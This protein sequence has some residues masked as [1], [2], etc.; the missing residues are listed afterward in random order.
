MRSAQ[1][2]PPKREGVNDAIHALRG[3]CVGHQQPTPWA[4][5]GHGI[6]ARNPRLRD[7]SPPTIVPRTSS[8]RAVV[9]DDSSESNTAQ[10]HVD[11]SEK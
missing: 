2:A 4:H 3:G 7:R 9:G 11:K 1:V 5:Y 10:S 6:P 8:V